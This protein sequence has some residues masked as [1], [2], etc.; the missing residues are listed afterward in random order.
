MFDMIATNLLS[1]CRYDR[2]HIGN[3]TE[4]SI[5]PRLWLQQEI[6]GEVEDKELGERGGRGRRRL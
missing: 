1:H 4:Y 5:A 2:P 6:V 3:G